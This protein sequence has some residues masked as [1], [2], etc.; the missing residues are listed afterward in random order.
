MSQT[1]RQDMKSGRGTPNEG[2]LAEG[3]G[4]ARPREEEDAG[5]QG[6]PSALAEPSAP[7][8]RA[9]GSPSPA[10]NASREGS[11]VGSCRASF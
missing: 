9:S 4:E 7:V 5:P 10:L 8:L 11:S 2:S 3:Q 6:P 1:S